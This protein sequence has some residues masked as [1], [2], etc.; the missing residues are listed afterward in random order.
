MSWLNS[1]RPV[2]RTTLILLISDLGCASVKRRILFFYDG[3]LRSLPG[4]LRIWIWLGA[5]PLKAA[6]GAGRGV[7]SVVFTENG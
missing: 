7:S 4:W 6:T 1:H 3:R 2:N 5:D